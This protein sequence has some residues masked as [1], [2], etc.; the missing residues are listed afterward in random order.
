MAGI[1]AYFGAKPGTG[2]VG[3]LVGGLAARGDDVAD[4]RGVR[5]E[6]AV[7][8]G[9]PQVHTGG[10]GTAVVVDGVAQASAI[11]RR[12]AERGSA[13]VL[14]AFGGAAEPEPFAMALA[15]PD[16]GVL[17]LARC[18]DGPTLYYARRGGE[19]LVASEPAGLLAAGVPAIWDG[20]VIQ[21]FLASGECDGTE[22]TFY[23]RIRQVLP[24]QVLEVSGDG[25]HPVP[26]VLPARRTASSTSAALQ[27]ATRQGH[28][29]VRL[30]GQIAGVALLGAAL[31]NPDRADRDTL[32]VYAAALPG[33]AG[34]RESRYADA[35]LAGLV[36]GTVR[37]QV[38]PIGAA[39]LDDFLADL[40]EP[41]PDPA[42][43]LAWCAAREAAGEVAALLDP[44]GAA[45][46]LAGEPA[47]P[48]LARLADRVTTRF[49]VALRLPYR[50]VPSTGEA[51]RCELAALARR[52]LPAGAARLA[53]RRV[54]DELAWHLLS[55]LRAELYGTFLSR[56]FAIRG[57]ADAQV[58]V[59]G[60][61][62]LLAGRGGDPLRFWR[63]FVVERW[64]RRHDP[65]AAP[66]TGGAAGDH[67]GHRAG[68][69]GDR[70]GHRA[71]P[72]ANPGRELAVGMAGASWLRFP[73][74]TRVLGPAD[75]FA[76]TIAWY[77]AELVAALAR[78]GRYRRQLSRPWYL[79]VAAKPLAV[80]QGRVR[81]LWE[82]RPGWW[83]RRISGFV[84]E[85]SWRGLG[86]PWTMQLAI[87]EVGLRRLLFAAAVAACGRAVRRRGVFDRLAGARAHAVSGPVEGSV[88]PAN[89]AVAAAPEEP[90]DAAGQLLAA[91]RAALPEELAAALAGCGIV[92]ADGSVPRVLGTAGDAA[93]DFYAAA[94][95]D[96]P[97]GGRGA[98]TPAVVVLP[99]PLPGRPA[100]GSGA[101]K[102]RAQPVPAGRRR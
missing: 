89:V 59:A 55:A 73:V 90:A 37:Q 29:G 28:L 9:I 50:D 27:A 11:L 65:V 91:A 83:A 82:V 60:F 2:V 100:G 22:R 41:V 79:A 87:D 26:V 97:M 17:V 98:G 48:Y 49:G 81:P 4:W 71:G 88:Y 43:L 80:A 102:R 46:L 94:C 62:E 47:P 53:D 61:G 6:L 33:E 35:V 3:A 69:A 14:A 77:V 75:R 20:E 74:R 58:T 38:L 101:T 84:R 15:D 99:A 95:A 32:P 64:L 5:L 39:D 21:R 18:V 92:A 24:G 63:E 30:G 19:V 12:Y 13:A 67:A 34:P 72:A 25:V 66:G 68:P 40:G 16:R 23:E 70:A 31:A 1:A 54:P 93:A 44:T 42:A 96:D 8:A 7:R 56:S 85:R 78:D 76:D 52:G 86:N 51:L 57:W 10:Y 36:D 45:A